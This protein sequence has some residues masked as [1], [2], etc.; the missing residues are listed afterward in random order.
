MD[1]THPDAADLL[2]DLLSTDR[3]VQFVV[4]GDSMRPFLRGGETVV[5]RRVSAEQIGLGDL[6]LCRQK[7][8]GQDRLLLHRAVAIY[9]HP[10]R[11]VLIQTH[12]DALWAPDAP[13]AEDQILGR[14][15]AI[16]RE[17]ATGRPLSL[18]TPGERLR[19]LGMALW[20]RTLWRI[21]T[22]RLMLI[23]CLRQWLSKPL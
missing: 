12:G 5:V 8:S 22:T 14:V 17:P 6:L 11:P 2:R 15:C 9:R 3:T 18:E 13:V 7:T 20:L 16:L 4:T 23:G 10:G 1:L 19:A 21:R